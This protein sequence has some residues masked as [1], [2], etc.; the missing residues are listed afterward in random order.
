[1][2]E[3]N[4]QFLAYFSFFPLSETKC[5]SVRNSDVGVW[6]TI[7]A[8]M[9]PIDDQNLHCH[10]SE[11]KIIKNLDQ[12]CSEPRLK[13][14]KKTK[15]C[16]NLFTPLLAGD[17]K[18]ERKG[19]SQ[20]FWEWES[21]TM[22]VGNDDDDGDDDDGWW[23]WQHGWADVDT[24]CGNRMKFSRNNN[25]KEIGR[26]SSK[27]WERQERERRNILRSR[28]EPSARPSR[29]SGTGPASAPA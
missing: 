1:M 2:S 10:Q 9:S 19:R 12:N 7:L 8:K 26:T 21:M 11:W 29:A 22:M 17:N 14:W 15:N 25:N 18:T 28:S 16:Q 3:T 13:S 23:W 27:W 4:W 24:C 6:T 20:K 5:W